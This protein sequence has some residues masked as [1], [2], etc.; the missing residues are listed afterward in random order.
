MVWP[1]ICYFAPDL[2]ENMAPG[3]SLF[4]L[5]IEEA[6]LGE[7]VLK[8][9]KYDPATSG[10]GCHTAFNTESPINC[11]GNPLFFATAESYGPCL[12]PENGIG[13]VCDYLAACAGPTQSANPP[14]AKAWR[15]NSLARSIAMEVTPHFDE[16]F[17]SFVSFVGCKAHQQ[18]L[19]TL[20]PFAGDDAVNPAFPNAGERYHIEDA[21]PD[22]RYLR[23]LVTIAVRR[24]LA[25]IPN[26]VDRWDYVGGRAW[27]DAEKAAY[28]AGHPT[29]DA[30]LVAWLGPKGFE[31]LSAAQPALYRLLVVPAPG[32][33]SGPN[34]SATPT[35]AGCETCSPVTNL[36]LPAVVVGNR[37]LVE[38][39][40]VDPEAKTNKHGVYGVRLDW[41]DG[42]VESFPRV[43]GPID[44]YKM[45]H[46]YA[47]PGS[48]TIE[49]SVVGTCGLR[50]SRTKTVNVGAG[51]GNPGLQAVE[52]IDLDLE[53]TIEGYTHGIVAVDVEAI[54]AQSIAYPVGRYW[55]APVGAWGSRITVD[56]TTAPMS[57]HGRSEIVA[58]RLLPAHHEAGG[59]SG[60]WFAEMTLSQVTLGYHASTG[61]MP[62]SITYP[63]TNWDVVIHRAGAPFPQAPLMA[64]GT[65]VLRLP[66]HDAAIVVTIPSPGI[67]S[68]AYGC[69]PTYEPIIG[70]PKMFTAD[71]GCK[72][73]TGLVWSLQ[74]PQK[75]SW[76]DAIWDAALVGNAPPDAFDAGRTNDYPGGVPLPANQYPDISTVNHC[77]TLK[78]GGYDDWR[79]PTGAELE[80]IASMATTYFAEDTTEF[81]WS[82]N[83]WGWG[84]DR[85]IAY[86]LSDGWAEYPTKTTAVR[87]LCVRTP[88]TK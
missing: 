85:T 32:E 24:V 70:A 11:E 26:V 61:M 57:W 59:P 60:S 44:A 47:A 88:W 36:Q 86:R 65:G 52:T 64:Y 73:K 7:P 18:A 6:C 53:A 51:G 28:L 31:L 13:C 19:L 46:A 16:D 22:G 42:R 45:T 30:E 34:A 62:T 25:G 54:D 67:K 68:A 3:W 41:G 27:T 4:G 8:C 39:S 10:P 33:V 15:L 78:Q 1:G 74:S 79:M 2:L 63:L 76:H 83:T 55:T 43:A 84:V 29:P 40:F 75:M 48:Y 69:R 37:V 14:G 82:A 87:A 56:L 38:P 49:M 5:P 80:K 9:C 23:G 81:V 50:S 35:V 12:T 71:G 17:I 21:N 72:D 77:H 66:L 58:L 20:P